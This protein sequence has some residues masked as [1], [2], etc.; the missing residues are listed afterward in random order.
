V[1]RVFAHVQA[2]D[3]LGMLV[4]L[5]QGLYDCLYARGDALFE[6]ADALLCTTGPVKTLVELSLAAEHRRG[7]GLLRLI[8]LVRGVSGPRQ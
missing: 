2:V 3:P 8:Q 5:R 7:R 4:R 1:S 6:L